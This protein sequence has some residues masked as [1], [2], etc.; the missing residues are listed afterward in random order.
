MIGART[1]GAA[2]RALTLAVDWAR[3]RVQF[4]EPLDRPPVD[5]GHDRRLASRR[6]PPTAR[7]PSGGLGGR[8]GRPGRRH[9]RKTLHAKAATVK[10]AASEASNRVVD[11]AVQI[12]GGRGYIRDYPVERLWRE[13]R[14]DRIWEGTSEIQRLV[15]ANETNKRGLETCC[16]SDPL[17]REVATCRAPGSGHQSRHAAARA[18]GLFGSQR[19]VRRV[20]LSVGITCGIVAEPAVRVAVGGRSRIGLALS[21]LH[22]YQTIDPAP[23]VPRL[24]SNGRRGRQG[25]QAGAHRARADQEARAGGAQRGCHGGAAP[26][27]NAVVDRMEGIVARVERIVGIGES[28]MSPLTATEQAVRGAVNKVRRTTGL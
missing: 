22:D 14:V 1:I 16:P 25:W 15:I 2:E 8:Q 26:R 21:A 7:Y 6:S 23:A 17:R 18:T 3:E 9:Q 20:R 13:L 24:W 10:L 28:V 5:P 4:G 19:R 12:F 27:L 11:R